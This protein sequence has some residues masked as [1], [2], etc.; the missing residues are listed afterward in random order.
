MRNPAN[1]IRMLM[2]D[3]DLI[4][5]AKGPHD[6]LPSHIIK[7]VFPWIAFVHLAVLGAVDQNKTTVSLQN[8]KNDM[9]HLEVVPRSP[10]HH[11]CPRKL[12]C[13]D[14]FDSDSGG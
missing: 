5:R 12:S 4:C 14:L 6:P 2:G 7:G 13:R 8:L 10:G 9:G 3:H 11:E 1:M